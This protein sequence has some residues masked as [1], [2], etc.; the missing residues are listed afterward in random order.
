MEEFSEEMLIVNPLGMHI[1]PAA[2]LVETVLPFASEV[3]LKMDGHLPVNAKSIMGVL[4]L[5]APQ[6][7]RITVICKGPDAG[8]ALDAV[9]ALIASGF[10]E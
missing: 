6:G 3:Y 4:T 1:R 9:R 2:K 5:L 8:E 7:S 10:G